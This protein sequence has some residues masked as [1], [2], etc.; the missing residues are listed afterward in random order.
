MWENFV[1]HP[2]VT[3]WRGH[4]LRLAEYGRC[5][6]ETLPEGQFREQYKRLSEHFN[7]AREGNLEQPPWMG[8]RAFHKSHLA[9]L[10]FERPYDY[11]LA[12]RT[13]QTFIHG[14]KLYWPDPVTGR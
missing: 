7:A 12:W 2:S 14:M 5:L 13:M 9:R 1:D 6:V 4:E 10:A 11:P 8:N 3:L